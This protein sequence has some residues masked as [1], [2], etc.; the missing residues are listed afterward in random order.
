MLAH[1][2]QPIGWGARTCAVL[3]RSKGEEAEKLLE[4]PNLAR[5]AAPI[6]DQSI[7]PGVPR[8]RF[9]LAQQHEIRARLSYRTSSGSSGHIKNTS[10]SPLPGSERTVDAPCGPET[11]TSPSSHWNRSMATD[12]ISAS[13]RA[14]APIS[15]AE[16]IG[17]A[18]LYI[19]ICTIFTVARVY[20]RFFVHQQ[21]WWDDCEY[22]HDVMS[23]CQSNLGDYQGPCFSLGWALLPSAPYNSSCSN[24]APVSISG[25]FRNTSSKS[26]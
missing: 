1:E 15:A 19:T 10:T 5:P 26:S 2:A 24:T 11:L 3:C 12:A 4:N 25:R 20:T 14:E 17:V 22:R 16:F 6:D 7:S 8:S 13:A 18:A 9:S 21:L 23:S